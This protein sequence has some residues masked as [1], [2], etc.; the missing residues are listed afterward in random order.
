[1][2]LSSY[3]DYITYSNSDVCVNAQVLPKNAPKTNDFTR[4]YKFP[5]YFFAIAFVHMLP[6]GRARFKTAR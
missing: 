4:F 6:G 1:M 3:A 5:L 2:K